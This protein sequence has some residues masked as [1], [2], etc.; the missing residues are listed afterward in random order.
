MKKLFLS[1]LFFAIGASVSY[2]AD[3]IKVQSPHIPILIN[4]YDNVLFN[5]R[6]D[7]TSGKTLDGITIDLGKTTKLSEIASVKLFYGGTEGLNRK[8]EYMAPVEYISRSKVGQTHSANESYSRLCGKIVSPKSSQVQIK[9]DQPL[10][11]GVN[12]FWVSIEMKPKTSLLSTIDAQVE[13]VTIDGNSTPIL[14]KGL[15]AARR[16]GTGVR[17]AGDDNV[18]AY[19][20]PGLVTTNDGS[21]LAVYDVR[22]NNSAD[23]Q[24]WIDV[25]VSR[26]TDKGQTW[27]KMRIAMAFG[28]DGGL[29][30]GQNGVGDPA[31][32][33]DT[34]T[35]AI[36]IV[37]AWT[38]GMGNQR[39]W[40]NSESGNSKDRTAQLMLVKSTDDGKTWS[41]PINVTEQ[42]KDESWKFLLQGPGMGITMEDGTLVFPTQFIDSLRMPHS[43]IMYSKDNGNSWKMHNGA[44]PNTTEAQV[45]EVEPGVLM[46]NMRDNRGGSRNVMT[47]TDFGKTWQDHPSTRSVLQESVCMASLIKVAAKDNALGKDILL[48]ANPNTTKGRHSITIK[49]SLDGGLTFPYE[50]LLDEGHGWGYSCLTMVDK[51]T[52]GIIYEGSV[53][54]MVYQNVKLSDIVK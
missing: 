33:V 45:A 30:K 8:G 7:N 54:H 28:E 18:E 27:E 25:G 13:S 40:F 23:L 39:A 53:A 44:H 11:D 19:R 21:L 42:V 16:M 4:R 6:L 43:G 5:L 34:K 3:T 32:L 47:T 35:G 1:L 31:I 52:V 36:W 46:L 22:Y 26:S 15:W 37:A 20:I 41:K 17:Y 10:Y 24:E 29:P 14:K 51:N 48:F 50:L 49:A 2:A 12:Y 38:H 9:C